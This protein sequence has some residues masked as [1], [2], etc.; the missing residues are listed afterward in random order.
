VLR[1]LLKAVGDKPVVTTS[2][3]AANMELLLK[4]SRY[5]RRVE[6]VDLAPRYDVRT[7]ETRVRPVADALT[8]FR[9]SRKA[10]LFA[11][12]AGGVA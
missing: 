11:A 10:R 7:R 6:T 2:G 5:A 4:A 3:W 1:E 12:P 8:L 9:F